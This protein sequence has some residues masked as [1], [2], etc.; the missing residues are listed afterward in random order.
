MIKQFLLKL[1]GKRYFIKELNFLEDR[2]KETNLFE[3]YIFKYIFRD[4]L[5]WD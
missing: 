4:G 5:T 1:F 3:Y 2:L